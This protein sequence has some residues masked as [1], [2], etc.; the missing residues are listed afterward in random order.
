MILILTLLHII[1]VDACVAIAIFLNEII[2]TCTRS[3]CVPVHVRLSKIQNACHHQVYFEQLR[4][5]KVA[6]S[7]RETPSNPERNAY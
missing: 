5:E 1:V 4:Q 7:A 2:C 3:A 6:E